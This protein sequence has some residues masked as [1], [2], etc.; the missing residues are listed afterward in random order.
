M[1]T[2]VLAASLLLAGCSISAGTMVRLLTR[3]RTSDRV[4]L[5]ACRQQYAQCAERVPEASLS[6]TPEGSVAGCADV[7]RFCVQTCE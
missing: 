1:R 6:Y 4:C 5:R 7:L 2:I 3:E